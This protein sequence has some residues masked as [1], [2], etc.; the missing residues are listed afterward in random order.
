MQVRL[1][2]QQ[3]LSQMLVLIVKEF[4]TISF[5][6]LTMEQEPLQFK[7]LQ[8]IVTFMHMVLLQRQSVLMLQVVM[9][10]L[11]LLMQQRVRK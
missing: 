4:I 9:Y 10:L 6:K 8:E 11:L 1:I 2:L 5:L 3:L 7:L